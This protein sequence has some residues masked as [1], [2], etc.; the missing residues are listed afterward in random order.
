MQH[1]IRLY[2]QKRILQLTTQIVELSEQTVKII[3]NGKPVILNAIGLVFAETIFHPQ[4][5]GQPSDKGTINSQT[6]IMVNEDKSQP[7][8]QKKIYH[9]LDLN[10]VNTEK[11][12][13][14]QKV[15]LEVNS[16]YRYQCE[17]SHSA[18]HLIADILELDDKFTSY[19]AKATRGH[20]FP[21]EEYIKVTVNTIP[22]DI[23]ILIKQINESL[24][25]LINKNLPTSINYHEDGV[26]HIKFGNSERMCG[27]THVKSTKELL[28]CEVTKIKMSKNSNGTDEL[29][30]FYRC[31]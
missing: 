4:G 29:T 28:A 13:I 8:L 9:F 26:R 23:P 14:G 21:G 1:S 7:L 12:S 11:Y 10:Q 15:Q 19:Q 24:H 22:T 2:E 3:Q 27:G 18:G 25:E 31:P 17:R 16:D 6:V 30:I 5:G 20:H